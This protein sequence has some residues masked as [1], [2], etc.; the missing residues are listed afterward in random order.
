MENGRIMANFPGNI[1]N[2]RQ[3]HRIIGKVHGIMDN[4]RELQRIMGNFIMAS[5]ISVMVS[6]AH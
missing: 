5:W 4:V 6:H 3:L 2:L 1:V